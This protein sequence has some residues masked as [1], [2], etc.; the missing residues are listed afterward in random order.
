MEKLH[1]NDYIND[2]ETDPAKEPWRFLRSRTRARAAEKTYIRDLETPTRAP[3]RESPGA[4]N[5]GARCGETIHSR[6]GP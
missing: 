6:F 4:K 1:I 5:Q 3:W 2:L